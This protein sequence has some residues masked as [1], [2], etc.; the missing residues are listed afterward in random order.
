[1]YQHATTLLL[2][3]IKKSRSD[4]VDDELTMSGIRPPVKQPHVGDVSLKCHS[5]IDIA[6]SATSFVVTHSTAYAVSVP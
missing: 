4:A 1:M 5:V 2:Q 6:I 3:T